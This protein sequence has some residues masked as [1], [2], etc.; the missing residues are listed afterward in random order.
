[1]LSFTP[2][3]PSDTDCFKVSVAEGRDSTVVSAKGE[4]DLASAP[5][6]TAILHRVSRLDAPVLLDLSAVEF[7][8][9]SGL[10][11]LEDASSGAERL[12]RRLTIGPVSGA[13]TRILD[14]ADMTCQPV[15]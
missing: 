3:A 8:D 5:L 11:A 12:G 14:L 2:Q 1:M 10:H 4:I 9:T 15:A 6:L 7:M 13:V